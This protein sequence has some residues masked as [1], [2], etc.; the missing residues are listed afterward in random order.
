MEI[1]R[2]GGTGSALQKGVIHV[3]VGIMIE[4]MLVPVQPGNQQGFA[5]LNR[6]Q[7]VPHAPGLEIGGFEYQDEIPEGDVLP[8]R[9]E[10]EPT[11]DERRFCRGGRVGH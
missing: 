7:G 5:G 6:G 4:G 2:V 10:L 8:R 9:G 3:L 1:F 11:L